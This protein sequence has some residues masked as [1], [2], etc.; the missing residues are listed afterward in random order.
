MVCLENFVNPEYE[1]HF[2]TTFKSVSYKMSFIRKIA[3]RSLILGVSY[4]WE[5]TV[6]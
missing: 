1:N 5:L 6:T 3:T 2:K 4:S